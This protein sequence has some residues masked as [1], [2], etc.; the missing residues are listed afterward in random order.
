MDLESDEELTKQKENF[1]LQKFTESLNKK[2]KQ[3]I[4]P[5]SLNIKKKSKSPGVKNEKVQLQQPKDSITPLDDWENDYV[6]QKTRVLTNE[7]KME[8]VEVVEYIRIPKELS[9][10]QSV[11]NPGNMK[12]KMYKMKSFEDR[13]LN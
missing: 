12:L 8:Q 10:T 6:V 11:I 9:V 7:N 13:L 1:D 2:P 5:Q 4:P 3:Y